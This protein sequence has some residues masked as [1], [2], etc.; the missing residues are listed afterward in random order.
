[1]KYFYR[2]LQLPF[3]TW[4]QILFLFGLGRLLSLLYF[5]PENFFSEVTAL[6]IIELFLLAARIDCSVAT[7]FVSLW[8]PVAYYCAYRKSFPF[9]LKSFQVYWR[10]IGLGLS[11]LFLILSHYFYYYYQDNFNILF[12]EFFA[13]VDNAKLVI[14]SFYDEL[15]LKNLFLG[16]ALFL[17]FVK[18]SSVFLD[19]IF[20][21]P[22]FNNARWQSWLTSK[23]GLFIL[24]LLVFMGIRA[25]FERA[26]LLHKMHRLQYWSHPFLNT[27]HANPVTEMYLSYVEMSGYKEDYQHEKPNIT[28]EEILPA[29]KKVESLDE[30]RVLGGNKASNLAITY[31]VPLTGSKVLNRKPKHIILIFMESYAKWV[32]DLKSDNFN[33]M[34]APTYQKLKAE[35]LYFDNYYFVAGGTASNVL[36]TLLGIPLPRNLPTLT[37]LKESYK[38]FDAFPKQMRR[39]GFTSTFYLGSSLR[40]HNLG[41]FTKKIGFAKSL[42][43]GSI[44][45]SQRARYGIYDEDL[46]NLV[47]QELVNAKSSSFHFVLTTNNHPPYQ[48]PKSF[49][50]P[51]ITIP[52]RLKGKIKDP[53]NFQKR[54]SSFAYADYALGQFIKK[55]SREE[56]FNETLFIITADHAFNGPVNWQ[57]KD[58]FVTE[59]IPLLFYSPSLIKNPGQKYSKLGNHLDLPPTILS[60]ILDQEKI[61]VGWGTSLFSDSKK[62]NQTHNFY[63]QCNSQYCLYHKKIFKR[64]LLSAK[65]LTS[66]QEAACANEKQKLLDWYQDLIL[67]GAFYYFN[68]Q[69]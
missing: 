38:P 20:N 5:M 61:V 66:C 22:I 21:L 17:L 2:S 25:T 50:P 23:A 57:D 65:D 28:F 59:S 46:F 1:M 31:R 37:S 3:V 30:R 19:K 44:P 9:H 67:T 48:M 62:T 26:P 29:F 56:Y 47:H 6:N 64:D 10:W 27:L 11:F 4:I 33:L 16:G 12:W 8:L 35:S 13:S 60:L 41:Y 54:F 32:L 24:P 45:I 69:P 15:P 43:E 53:D 68:Y 39:E 18:H 52:S 51:K 63:L 36:Q 14:L 34:V 42:G 49:Q 55:A 40:W 7:L 58:R